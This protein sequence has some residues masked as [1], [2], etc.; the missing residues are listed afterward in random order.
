MAGLLVVEDAPGELIT[1]APFYRLAGIAGAD[2]PIYVKSVPEMVAKLWSRAMGIFNPQMHA[3]GIGAIDCLFIGGHGAPGDQIRRHWLRQRSDR[4]KVSA[5]RRRN[6]GRRRRIGAACARPIVQSERRRDI[7]WMRGSRWGEGPQSS[8]GG[9]Q[10]PGRHSRA[11]GDRLSVHCARTPPR[12]CVAGAWRKGPKPRPV[13]QHSR[14]HR[15]PSQS[16]GR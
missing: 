8:Y 3:P 16:H 2:D 7:G 9:V 14:T 1:S 6:L 12:R 5:R 15:G 10:G 13:A 4:D 11:G